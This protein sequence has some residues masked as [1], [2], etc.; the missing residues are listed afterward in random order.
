M[1]QERIMNHVAKDSTDK[2][3]IIIVQKGERYK[4]IKE[5][6]IAKFPE[7]KVARI[8]EGNY[9][10]EL[11][12]GKVVTSKKPNWIFLESNDVAMLSN[13]IPLLNAKAESH[14]ITLFTSDKNSAFDDDSVKNEHLS[15]LHLHYASFYKEF[16]NDE[17][18][19]NDIKS[20]RSF[21]KRY[22]KK[23]G[24]EPGNWAIRGFDIMY[25]VLLRLG[26][27]DDLYHGVTFDGTTEYV[28]NKFRYTKK[29]LGGYAN[30]ATYLVKF[31]VDL[32]LSI[33]D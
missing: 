16:D 22:K 13:V 7:A 17:N 1:L 23:Y 31:D 28:E 24:I 14:K 10:Y 30:T 4:E 32:K 29:P 2:N 20:I 3:I 9:L 27:A 21:E 6:L 19:K 5:K 11:H 25:D 8:E 33:V 18:N 12:L 15:N 26:A